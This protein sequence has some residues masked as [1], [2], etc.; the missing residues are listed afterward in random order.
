MCYLQIDCVQVRHA[1]TLVIF[2]FFI[3][4]VKSGCDEGGMCVFVLSRVFCISMGFW[5]CLGKCSGLNMFPIRD[6]CLSLSLI[7]DHI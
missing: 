1:L 7:G 3:I 6:S 5:D 4:L 2:V